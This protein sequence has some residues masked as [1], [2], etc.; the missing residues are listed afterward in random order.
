MLLT[1]STED[2]A[3]TLPPTA[4]D[5]LSLTSSA[6][7]APS[8]AESGTATV[9]LTS[10]PGAGIELAQVFKILFKSILD[11]IASYRSSGFDKATI[12]FK[13]AGSRSLECYSARKVAIVVLESIS[14]QGCHMYRI[15]LFTSSYRDGCIIRLSLWM[16]YVIT[17]SLDIFSM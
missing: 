3:E 9:N 15:V 6:T 8:L 11:F 10:R 5:A 7:E 13:R 1:N 12:S 17:V 4:A 2:N 16:V 14:R